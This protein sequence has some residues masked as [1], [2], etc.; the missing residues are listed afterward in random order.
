VLAVWWAILPINYDTLYEVHLFSLLPE[1]VAVLIALSWSGLRMR[2][3]V[4]AALLATAVLMRN[5]VVIAL[6]IWTAAWIAY[7]IHLSRR[8]EPTPAADLARAFGIPTLA[9][10]VI[11]AAVI[12]SFPDR[13]ELRA[14]LDR[15]HTLNVCQIYAFGYEQRNDD[16]TASPWTDCE[17][18]MQRDF[19][20][21][22]PSMTA[23]LAANPGAM[24]EHFLW[25]ARLAPFG[26]QLML[27]DRIS[28]GEDMN[29]D[30]AP[31]KGGSIV[32]LLG[33]ILLVALVLGGLALLW[34]ERRR[35]RRAWI[36]E[37]AWG[38]LALGSLGTTAMV[39]ALTQRPRPS[40][41]FSLAVLILAVIGMCA[42]AYADRWPAVKSLRAAVPALA[43]VILIV[44][45]PHYG[46][47]YVTPQI[48]APGRPLKAMVDRLDPF[49]DDLRGD[50]IGLLA[51]YSGPGC[52]YIGR[53]DP[54][55]GVG[56]QETG[57]D[58]VDFVYADQFDL[59]NPTILQEVHA[60]ERAGWSRLAP[61]RPE[62]W[63]LLGR[64]GSGEPVAG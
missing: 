35:W 30:Y 2:A 28:A 47:T 60:L 32:A 55:R 24:G 39:V 5:E 29:P 22:Q 16:Y 19:G 20:E 12:V 63:L 31:V 53:A 1:L 64:G 43:L 38:W 17:P 27:F 34:R 62:G 56:W 18:L 36:R 52:A 45:P 54:C 51:T 7:E 59:R 15:K 11:A 40:Y 10:G 42:M 6:V 4:F 44:V 14:S 23:A 49:H 25:N 26:L 33:L 37:R 41:L 13:G 46:L 21:R 50:D 57:G 48:G 9:V 58:D 3:G 8:G 61:A